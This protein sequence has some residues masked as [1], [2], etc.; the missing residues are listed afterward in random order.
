MRTIFICTL[1]LL[2]IPLG[3][4][5][6]VAINEIAWMGS[7][8]GGVDPKQN[9]RYEWV[10]L[11]NNGDIV[12]LLN[13]W[14]LELYRDKLDF[15]IP[16]KGA[17]EPSGYFLIGASEKIQGLDFNYKN[18]AGKFNNSGQR[19]VL[20][21]TLGEVIDEVDATKGWPAGDNKT[22]RTM[23]RRAGTGL[24][25]QE[26]WQ[27]SASSGGTPKAQNSKGFAKNL[28]WEYSDDRSYIPT[29]PQETKKDPVR[30]SPQ[31]STS[32]INGTTLS[33]LA[34]ALGSSVAVVLLRRRLLR[35]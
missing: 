33:A 23:E 9:W 3:V 8:V 18:L 25:L 17:I 20:K 32:V 7:A 5:A 10:E 1:V 19:V 13:G 15:R 30:S 6:Q 28:E 35:A 26:K 21:N 4:L 24:A 11:Y 27:T 34:F 29:L 14:A 2:L 31:N 22:K 12:E 16:L